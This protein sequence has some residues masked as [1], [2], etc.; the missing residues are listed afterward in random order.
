MSINKHDSQHV[1]ISKRERERVGEG[2][3]WKRESQQ[4]RL[5]CSKLRDS[6][7]EESVCGKSGKANLISRKAYTLTE[8]I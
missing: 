7:D 2:G 3:D 6:D 4:A 1:G 5:A 8:H